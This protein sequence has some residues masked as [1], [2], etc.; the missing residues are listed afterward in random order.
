MPFIIAPPSALTPI[1]P[2]PSLSYFLLSSSL[3]LSSK[4]I[5]KYKSNKIYKELHAENY[6]TP[7]KI[8]NKSSYCS[9]R[10]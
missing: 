4:D 6:K 10:L 1:L 7:I 8:K 5:F 3:Y 9:H 2:F